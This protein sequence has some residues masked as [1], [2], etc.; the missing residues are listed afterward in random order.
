MCALSRPKIAFPPILDYILHIVRQSSL[1]VT[2]GE[3]IQ[4]MTTRYP[5]REQLVEI[6]QYQQCTRLSQRATITGV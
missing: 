4:F 2:F 3:I 1:P 6:V 5:L